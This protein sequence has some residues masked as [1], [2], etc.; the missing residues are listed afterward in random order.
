MCCL[1]GLQNASATMDER[2]SDNKWGN[3][4]KLRQ[5]AS[6]VL[7]SST[8]NHSRLCNERPKITELWHTTVGIVTRADEEGPSHIYIC[9][10]HLAYLK[11]WHIGAP[12]LLP[13]QT[14]CVRM[15]YFLGDSMCCLTTNGGSGVTTGPWTPD[16][17]QLTLGSTAFTS[18]PC[19]S[20]MAHTTPS[21]GITVCTS[22]KYGWNG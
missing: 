11:Q 21:R 13:P 14:C 18:P 4:R 1:T 6:P 2:W 15:M 8:T 22:I 17:W 5:K 19:T 9:D 20:A 3:V 16:S 12:P 7:T 10:S